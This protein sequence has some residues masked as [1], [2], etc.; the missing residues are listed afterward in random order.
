MLGFSDSQPGDWG[1]RRFRK[2]ELQHCF[3]DGWLI[4]SIE[5]TVL[6][7]TL[8]PEGARAWLAAFTRV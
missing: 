3:A 6:E 8:G 4:D 7:I 1:P 2:D 5:D